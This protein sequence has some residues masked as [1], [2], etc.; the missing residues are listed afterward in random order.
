MKPAGGGG[1]V[2]PSAVTCSSQAACSGLTRCG[3]VG[4]NGTPKIQLMPTRISVMP[5]TRMIVPVT[6]GGKNRSIRLASG[7]ISTPMMPAA[8][9]EPKIIRAPSAPGCAR[10]I[11]TI[12]PTDAKVTPII[13]GNLTPNHG[14]KPSD[15]R[16]E[17]TPQQNR[18]AEIRKATSSGGSCSTLPMIS[19]T[20][21]APAY[22][23]STCCRPRVNSFGGGSISSTG[24]TAVAI[25]LGSGCARRGCAFAS[26]RSAVARD[27]AD[28]SEHPVRADAPVQ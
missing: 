1:T 10:P 2:P 21:M 28:P 16:I 8:M 15:C 11:D 13:T 20:A 5:I 25:V 27:G 19:G 14:V 4:P 18:S 24:W 6:T 26:A 12:G 7:A 23:T 3:A 9:I 17:T 22:I